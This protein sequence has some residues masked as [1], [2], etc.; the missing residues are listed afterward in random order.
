MPGRMVD[1][2]SKNVKAVYI[3]HPT[4]WLKVF[5]TFMSPFLSKN[6]KERMVYVDSL[7]HIFRYYSKD[8]LALPE[9]VFL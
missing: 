1:R 2:Y 4:L 6:F 5:L 3:I 9:S 7:H 8:Q